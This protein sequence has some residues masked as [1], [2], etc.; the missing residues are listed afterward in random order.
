MSFLLSFWDSGSLLKYSQCTTFISR[1]ATFQPQISQLMCSFRR[2]VTVLPA[3]AG[4]CHGAGYHGGIFVAKLR[5]SFARCFLV[6][7]CVKVN[8]EW[9]QMRQ[10]G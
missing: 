1:H 3:T 8:K 5:M 4:A 9:L 6:I 10:Q 2:S 7:A